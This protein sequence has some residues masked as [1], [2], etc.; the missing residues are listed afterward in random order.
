MHKATWSQTEKPT[1]FI[2]PGRCPKEAPD[3]A[4][5]GPEDVDDEA[6]A[7][8]LSFILTAQ[9]YICGEIHFPHQSIHRN[10]YIIR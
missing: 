7:R 9:A 3:D 6:T 5:A 2:P 8:N 1:I 4:G 10:R